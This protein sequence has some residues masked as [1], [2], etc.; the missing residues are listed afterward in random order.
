ME[1]DREPFEH[2]QDKQETHI[3]KER[4]IE[5]PV[6]EEEIVA[7]TREVE[8]GSVRVHK[9][10]VEEERTIEVPVTEEDVNVTRRKVDREIDPDRHEFGEDVTVPVMGE[11]VEVEK[12]A[13]VVEEIEIHREPQT[14][15]EQ[16]TD[17]VRREE[18]RIEGEDV[19]AEES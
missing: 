16:V 7:E 6:T 2:R 1:N 19:E 18:V 9:D 5:V 17:T 3:H 11:E 15:T 10:V 14:R 4:E 12:T 8:R 13:R